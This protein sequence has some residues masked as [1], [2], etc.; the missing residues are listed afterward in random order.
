M[1]IVLKIVLSLEGE[2]VAVITGPVT[3]MESETDKFTRHIHVTDSKLH[4]LPRASEYKVMFRDLH[5][6]IGTFADKDGDPKMGS[7]CPNS[8]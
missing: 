1:L 5:D 2:D 6:A 3:T 4:G 8:R 7:I